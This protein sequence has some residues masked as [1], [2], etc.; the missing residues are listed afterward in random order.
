[1]RAG[2]DVFGTD[3]GSRHYTHLDFRDDPDEFHFLVIADNAGGARPGVLAKAVEMTN[4]LQPE[5]AVQVG[6]LIEGYTDD[7]NQLRAEWKEIDDIL[8]HLEVPYF[9]LPGNHD[10]YSE[11]SIRVWR[12]RFGDG[13]GYYHFV[14]K[15]VLFLM[16]NTEDPPLD[17][18][19]LQQD[20]PETAQQIMATMRVL[21]EKG[22][23]GALT[24]DDA[25]L[26]DE[27]AEVAGSINISDAQVDYF[28]DVLKANPDVRWT[29]CLTHAPP[30]YSPITG[31]KDPGNFSKIE[32][33]LSDRP[34]T[35]VS[36]HTHVYNYEQ[37]NGRDF[38]TTAT[39]GGIAFDRAGAMD[40]VTWVTMTKDGPKI[41]NLLMNGIIGKE[42]PTNEEALQGFRLYEQ[43]G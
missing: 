34:F 23:K 9:F 24:I 21:G 26:V 3:P 30:Y 13:R 22:A 29:F 38:I 31:E 5:F 6:D 8:G 41:A 43:Q 7:D 11:A 2:A 39:S 27:L 36:G 19:A 1:V 40:H 25:Q 4:L 32:A 20:D 17:M 10:Y 42:G 18:A 15:D 12:E 14:Y 33:H 37:R 35:V 16:V 28:A